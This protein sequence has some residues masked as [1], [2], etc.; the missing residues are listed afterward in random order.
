MDC[1]MS[2]FPVL[3]YLLEFAQSYVHWAGDAIQQSHPLPPPSPFAFNL[4]QHQGLFQW[5]HSLHQV[6]KVLELP[7]A[8]ASVFPMNIQGWLPLGLVWSCSPRDSQKSFP[9]PQFK[10]INSSALS[11]LYSSLL[12]SIHDY[13][14]NHSFDYKHLCWQT[15]V[16]AF[17]Y[18]V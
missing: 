3:H 17:Q 16:F 11:L 7:S 5:V 9:A 4:S 13:W 2:G 6:A 18:I 8:S 10:S 12:T 1:R 14:K 15:D